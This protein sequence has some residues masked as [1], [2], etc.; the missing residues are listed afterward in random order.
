[1]NI[2][3][4]PPSFDDCPMHAGIE[5]EQPCLCR[6]E[7]CTGSDEDIEGS[8]EDEEPLGRGNGYDGSY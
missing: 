3:Y 8:G 5:C 2:D 4:D 6:C 1:M 7:D